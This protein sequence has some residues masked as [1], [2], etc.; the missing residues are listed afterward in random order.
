[1][2]LE[3][4]RPFGYLPVIPWERLVQPFL[5]IPLLRLPFSAVSAVVRSNPL[6]IA[7][8]APLVGTAALVEFL[9]EVVPALPT[10]TRVDVFTTDPQVHVVAPVGPDREVIFHVPPDTLDEDLEPPGISGEQAEAS[11]ENPWL[12]WMVG[13]IAP[14]SVDVVHLICPGRLSS[15][16]GLLDFGA[17][18]TGSEG[19]RALRLVSAGQLLTCLTELGAS[20]VSFASL[21]R[22]EAALRIMAHRMTGLLSGPV[23]VHAPAAGY[24]ADLAG[25]FRFLFGAEPQPPPTSFG[26]S[27]L[28]PSQ[29][30][31]ACGRGRAGDEGFG[32]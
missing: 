11:L 27:N 19:D 18:P 24:A 10:R 21:G 22:G 15:N 7:L 26:R 20:S 2:W 23:V 31:A 13:T 9:Q 32:A 28:L 17:P 5:G 6:R 25:A 29:S 8:C 12:R 30:A 16:F 3:F 14:A 4:R 1:M